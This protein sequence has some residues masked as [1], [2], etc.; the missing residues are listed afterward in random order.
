MKTSFETLKQVDGMIEYITEEDDR[1]LMCCYIYRRVLNWTPRE[2]F[3]RF[4]H[5]PVTVNAYAQRAAIIFDLP[6]YK[7]SI[8]YTILEGCQTAVKRDQLK[9]HRN[10]LNEVSKRI[11]NQLI[12]TA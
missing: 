2:V 7:H 8:Y 6:H 11:T 3:E 4:G 12:R 9:R 5:S 10:H 1:T